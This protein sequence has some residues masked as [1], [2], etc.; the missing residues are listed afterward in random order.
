[1]AQ[2]LRR[3][4]SPGDPV[5]REIAGGRAVANV[6]MQLVARAEG[7]VAGV[8]GAELWRPSLPAWRRAAT[9]ATLAVR[10]AGAA[11]D[12]DGLSAGTAPPEAPTVIVVDDAHA[13]M[14]MGSGEATSALWSS[15]P[16]VVT[17]ARA[18]IEATP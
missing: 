13:L 6:L 5:T 10:I 9:R 11:D 18:A 15:H 4:A 17:L 16:L 1:L 7:S 3:A 14:A 2:S 12:P 8:V